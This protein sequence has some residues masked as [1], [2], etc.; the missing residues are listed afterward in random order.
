MI[1]SRRPIPSFQ[2][3]CAGEADVQLGNRPALLWAGNIPCDRL[4]PK[5]I[6]GKRLARK[7]VFTNREWRAFWNATAAMPF[8]YGPLFRVLALTGQR[9]SEVG[10]ARWREFDLTSKLWTI[11]AE[12]MKADAP[13]LVPL[14]D[15]VTR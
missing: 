3:A 4:K 15:S 12:R 5:A 11:P 8:P 14:S 6:V 1:V 2:S 13:H 10:E 7:R 9:R